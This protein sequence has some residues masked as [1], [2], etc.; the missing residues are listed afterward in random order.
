MGVVALNEHVSAYFELGFLVL[1]TRVVML[2]ARRH[3]VDWFLEGRGAERK[4]SLEGHSRLGCP[5]R[6]TPL[7]K[8]MSLTLFLGCLL[9]VFG[10]LLIIFVAFVSQKAQNVILSMG[11]F[12][13]L[14]RTRIANIPIESLRLHQAVRVQ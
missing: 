9:Y 3:G 2:G 7:S 12:V 10:P 1:A 6:P 14:N 5:P 13:S 8:K 11:R 4:D